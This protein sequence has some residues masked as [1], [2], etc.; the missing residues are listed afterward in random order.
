MKKAV[1]GVTAAAGLW[2]LAQ[3]V[4][5]PRPLSE[6]TPAGPVMYLEARNLASVIA[7]WDQSQEKTAWLGSASFQVFSRSRLFLRLKEVFDQYAAATGV[8]PDMTMFRSVAG[9]ESALAIYDIGTLEFL[10]LT[11]V[12]AARAM[13]SLLWKA[14]EKF[15]TRNAG[16]AAYYVLNDAAS[17]RSASFAISGDLLLIATRE[18]ALAESL[19]L[20]AGAGGLTAVR[21]ES[22]FQAAAAASTQPG[23]LRML[24]HME[25]LVA[26]ASFR[27]YWVQRNVAD[28]RAFRSGV[29]DLRRADRAVQEDRVLLRSEPSAAPDTGGVAG[30]MP[31]A[32]NAGLYRAWA[33]P[34]PAD[35]AGLIA[36]KILL[37]AGAAATPSQS[38][39]SVSIEANEPGVET[40]LESRLDE[41]PLHAGVA[42]Q[43]KALMDL[44]E[45]ARLSAVLHRQ[46]SRMMQDNVFIS[47]DSLLAVA[48]QNNWDAAAVRAALESAIRGLDTVSSLG[49]G[50]RERRVGADTIWETDGLRG[51]AV[52]VRGRTLL[53]ATRGSYLESALALPAGANPAGAAYLAGYRPAAELP[54]YT[55]IMRMIEFPQRNP[56]PNAAQEPAFFSGNLGSLASALGRV[57]SVSVIAADDGKSL[58]QTVAYQLSR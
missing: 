25:R 51:L 40:D 46:T 48:G 29:V 13:E 5:A 21:G 39:P 53:L 22:W 1:I 42:Y 44:L 55:R 20:L 57:D 45:G 54:N 35:A 34:T 28:L 9:S 23:D 16:G 26:S 58:K 56:D 49:F 14:R 7:D 47:S 4:T 32:A 15:S 12:P 30:L 27:S 6:I 19:Q 31:L 10:Y 43:P 33:Q 50:W 8:P 18:T 2:M 3:N 24:L 52:A 37:A 38:A 17:R 36:E 41:A 11:R